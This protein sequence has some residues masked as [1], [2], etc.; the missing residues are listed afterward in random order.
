MQ[1]SM[2]IPPPIEALA[3]YMNEAPQ[4]VAESILQWFARPLV[5]DGL[6]APS[7][8]ENV[9]DFILDHADS[10]MVAQRMDRSEALSCIRSTWENPY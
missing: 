2:T 9:N 7:D 3:V 6:V 5:Q 4:A 10:Y 8:T 1:A